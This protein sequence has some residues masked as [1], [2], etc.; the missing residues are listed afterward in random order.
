MKWK[1]IY[2]ITTTFNHWWNNTNLI[3]KSELTKPNMMLFEK[4]ISEWVFKSNQFL[5]VRPCEWVSQEGLGLCGSACCLLLKVSLHYYAIFHWAS[6]IRTQEG[7]TSSLGGHLYQWLVAFF[8]F[9]H[10]MAHRKRP[11]QWV[12]YFPCGNRFLKKVVNSKVSLI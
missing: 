12:S 10:S 11:C 6:L 9:D 8:S 3:N 1:N 5:I 2:I 4:C 7:W